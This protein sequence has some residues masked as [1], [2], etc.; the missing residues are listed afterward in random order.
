MVTM[1]A[2]PDGVSWMVTVLLILVGPRA[3]K[4]EVYSSAASLAS[5]SYHK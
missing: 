1:S 2:E 4:A 5:L 3:E